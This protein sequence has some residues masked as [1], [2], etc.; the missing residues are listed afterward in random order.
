MFVFLSLWDCFYCYYEN[1]D[2]GHLRLLFL[3]GYNARPTIHAD[4]I[5]VR[6]PAFVGSRSSREWLPA[7]GVPDQVGNDVKTGGD[8]ATIIWWKNPLKIVK[9][10]V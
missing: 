10:Y 4:L 2:I 5:M 6:I 8:F 3:V 7:F 1:I 9:K